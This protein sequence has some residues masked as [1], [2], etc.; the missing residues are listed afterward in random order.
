MQL[1]EKKVKVKTQSVKDL[2]ESGET[3]PI[4][5]MKLTGRDISY[6]KSVIKKSTNKEYTTK[7]TTSKKLM[8]PC[9]SDKP[10]HYQ[11]DCI[12]MKDY[13]SQN[14]NYIGILTCLNTTSRQANARPFKNTDGKTISLLIKEII[15]EIVTKCENNK[16]GLCEPIQTLRTDN[17]PEFVNSDV[18]YMLE[19]LK[20]AHETAEADT[21]AWLNRTNRFHRT[22]R[23]IFRD[24]FEHKGNNKWV[25]L[26]PKIIDAYN[27]TPSQAFKNS[28]HKKLTPNEI[29]PKE[30][31]LIHLYEAKQAG[32]VQDHDTQ[33][34]QIGDY[35][36][37]R[38]QLTKAGK[39]D[40]FLKDSMEV[41]FTRKIYKIAE[42]NGPNTWRICNTDDTPI[43]NEVKIW[44]TYNLLKSKPPD[45]IIEAAPLEQFVN[46][47]AARK[48]R[49]EELSISA[50]EKV[51]LQ[52]G[53]LNTRTTRQSKPQTRSRV[54]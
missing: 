21:T 34:F 9:G 54:R 50:E 32:R 19:S 10:G 13:K 7:V 53:D 28:L 23:G 52:I 43:K 14:K 22:L 15:D 8:V 20:I 18:T 24:L 41:N 27:N 30:S 40:K 42:R 26:L 51:G 48:K 25:T 3:D 1:E 47:K 2:I 35:V 46:V 31:Q 44:Q 49:I 4:T 45:Q 12:F 37:L 16:A 17:G 38:Q 5:L 39:K 33:V 36:R 29:T 11:M 6:I